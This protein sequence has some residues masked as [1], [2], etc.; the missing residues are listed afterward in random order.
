MKSFTFRL[1]RLLRHARRKK[2]ETAAQWASARRQVDITL[3]E[4]AGHEAHMRRVRDNHSPKEGLP[5]S[6]VALQTAHSHV[7][8]H[9]Q[10]LIGNHEQLQQRQIS[11]KQATATLN[12][13]RQDCK[14]LEKLRE[15]KYTSWRS[16]VLKREQKEL[17]AVGSRQRQEPTR[18]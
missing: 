15:K 5:V 16:A 14:K 13:A 6:A 9:R 8:W 17:D 18:A 2:D 7:L 3:R 11:L 1:E 4:I 12:T 10:K